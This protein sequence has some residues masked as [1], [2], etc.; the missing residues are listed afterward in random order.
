[1]GGLTLI[2]GPA[3]FPVGVDEVKVRLRIDTTDLDD[4]LG[5]L[6][7]EATAKVEELTG[8]ALREQ[9]W[10]YALDGFSDPILLPKGPVTAVASIKYD[11]PAGAE[12]T[13]SASAY[14]VDLVSDPQ[15]LVLNDGYSW[16]D[17]ATTPNPVRVEFTS[18]YAAV[19]DLVVS[20]IMRTVASM[21]RDPEEGGVPAAA[22]AD[23]E[24]LRTGWFAA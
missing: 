10:E 19:P 15:A 7:P 9:V 12:Q 5:Q 16:P 3:S 6:I 17:V 23:L 4:L 13:L 21:L 20:A 8:R 22:K 18:G 14:S 2:T 11:D 1:M 24:S